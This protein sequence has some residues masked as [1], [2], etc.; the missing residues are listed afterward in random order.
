MRTLESEQYNLVASTERIKRNTDSMLEDDIIAKRLKR[1]L[2]SRREIE[3]SRGTVE[4][5]SLSEFIKNSVMETSLDTL[6]V[7]CPTD[8]QLCRAVNL[9]MNVFVQG[10]FV[11]INNVESKV[12]AKEIFQESLIREYFYEG[13]Y[14][15]RQNDVG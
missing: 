7:V 5:S 10:V 14:I 3:I 15:C 2:T 9:A 8:E 13:G 4:Y 11:N 1:R 12:K 6:S